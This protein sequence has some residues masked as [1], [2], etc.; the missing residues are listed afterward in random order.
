[1]VTIIL[2]APL[3]G[4]I[5]AG[6]GW[7]FIG[8]K[9]AQWTTTGLL[10]LAA[11]LSWIVFLTLGEAH[12]VTLFR[13]IESG[14]LS[15]DW[16]IRVDRLTAIMLIVIN[17][18]SAL[19]HLYS[20]GYMAHDPQ[21]EHTPYRARFFAYL[22]LFTFAML[23]LVTSDNLVQMFFGWEGVG[24]ASYL[25]IGFYYK[26]PSAGAAAI[27]AFVVNRVGDFGFALGIFGLFFL[28]DSIQFDNIF[29]AVPTIAETELHF[30]WTDWN[31]AE[32]IAFLLF[33][34]AMGKSAQLLLH[35]WLPDAMEGPTPV[36]ALIHAATMVTAGVFLVCRMSPLMEFAPNATAFIT[37]LGA[38]T[39][40]FAATIGLVQNDIKR[41]IAYST[42]SQLGYMF[43]AA[44]VGVYPVAMF[45]LLT[46]A[47][48][49]AMLF[50][51]AGSVI[52]AMH[53]EQ[54]MRNYGNLRHKIPL[55]FW[56]MMIGTLAITGVGIPLTG[57]LGFAGFV[58]K[59]AVI[60]SAW[61]GTSGGYAF[62]MLVIAA[63]FTSFY[64]WRLMFMTFY[65]K[66]RGDKHTHDH[67]HESPRVMTIPLGVLA[68][69]AIFSGMVFYSSFFGNHDKVLSFFGMP[70]HHAEA[71]EHG[72]EAAHGEETAM[73]D[74]ATGE[75]ADEAAPAEAS[76]EAA[77]EETATAD[78]ATEVG[79]E[80][81]ATA[82]TATEE[83]AEGTVTAD[84]AIEEGA[85]ATAMADDAAGEDGNHAA[86]AA[87]LEYGAIYMAPD[88]TVMDDAHHA[89]VWVKLTPFVAML[90]GFG[91]AYW[92]YIVN[93]TLPRK[94]AKQQRPLY[95]FLLNKWYF[96][97]AYDFLFVRSAKGLGRFFWKR[98]DGGVI[99]GGINGLAMGI[100]PFFTKLA[101]RAQ[102]GFIFTYA[103]AMVIGIVLLV[104]WMSI[105]GGAH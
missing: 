18:V 97:E 2:F 7:K 63:L 61:A 46:H 16:S 39:A 93:P 56:A 69:G 92:F 19:V 85:E 100:I 40:F 58:S 31:A 54:D 79:A 12:T 17:T 67:A 21:F 88:N 51:G 50:L 49:K 62:W 53:H 42:C 52:H 34:G 29:A 55:T 91:V 30:L 35:T 26:K 27:K 83:G 33:I 102:S 22:S 94:L 80:G 89:P 70:A 5:I 23:A 25:L 60:E 77:A 81:T 48:F 45:H 98:G 78:T 96:D 6:F 87:G 13:F 9:G 101:G 90:I 73:A 84:T 66:A 82:D 64:S 65:G 95:L 44:G 3:I 86:P 8:E 11:L 72:E 41:V 104:T 68:I 74:T 99:D 10:F 1:M 71:S 76:S 57:W 24:L 38:T 47:F 59:D 15:T 28:T 4:A 75:G 36:S 103:F 43:V 105:S 14:T 37:F 20:F 32:L